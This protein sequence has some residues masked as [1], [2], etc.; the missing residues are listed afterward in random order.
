[1]MEQKYMVT[2]TF[3]EENIVNEC[4][5]NTRLLIGENQIF[6]CGDDEY[7]AKERFN[8]LPNKDKELFLA[9][10]E[11]TMVNGKSIIKNWNKISE[12]KEETT[13]GFDPDVIEALKQFD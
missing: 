5:G 2:A 11:Y 6:Y 8:E 4:G 7:M 10:V 12:G 3:K 9:E 13:D 1:M